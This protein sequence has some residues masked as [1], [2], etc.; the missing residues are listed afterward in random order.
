M[1]K[2][3]RQKDKTV[4]AIW[5]GGKVKGYEATDRGLVSF[6]GIATIPYISLIVLT[7]FGRL[8]VTTAYGLTSLLTCKVVS[9]GGL[10]RPI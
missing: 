3:K 8:E 9:A 2:D 10:R 1:V 5:R 6:R 4:S 7:R